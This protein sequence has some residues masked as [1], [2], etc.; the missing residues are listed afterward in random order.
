MH[1][2]LFRILAAVIFFSGLG[3]SIFYR[4]KA[5]MDSGEQVSWQDEGIFMILALRLGGLL[6]WFGFIGYLIYPPLLAWSNVGLPDWARWIGVMLGA[7]CVALIYWLFSSIG[8]GISPTVATRNKHQLVTTGPYRWVRHPLYSVGSSFFIAL[9]LM[10][11]SWFIAVMA[12]LAFS[13]L[14]MRTPNEEAHLIEKF[15]DDYRLYMK[16]TGA[17]FPKLGSK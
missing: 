13:L 10:A 5:D 9:A 3:I 15:G 17:Y 1:E 7:I 12:V 8:Q 16:R 4:R 2:H 11:D 6:L 14:A